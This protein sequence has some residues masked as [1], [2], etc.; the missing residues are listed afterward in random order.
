MSTPT[1]R[2]IWAVGREL[3]R[4]TKEGGLK[5]MQLRLTQVTYKPYGG[6]V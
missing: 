6:M 2:Y 4:H 5:S 3:G 1:E